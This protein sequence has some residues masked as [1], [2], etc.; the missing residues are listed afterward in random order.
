MNVN[1]GESRMEVPGWGGARTGMQGACFKVWTSTPA[2]LFHH[3]VGPMNVS[4]AKDRS[5]QTIDQLISLAYGGVGLRLCTAHVS[6]MTVLE[7]ACVQLMMFHVEARGQFLVF[8]CEV[9]YSSCWGC[10]AA[11]Y[12]SSCY[13]NSLTFFCFFYIPS[14]TC[15]TSSTYTYDILQCLVLA[16]VLSGIHT[17]SGDIIAPWTL[18][19]IPHST[20]I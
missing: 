11:V 19:L 6:G 15:F 3:L 16:P 2:P 14:A 8:L 20:S 9:G 13:G 5:W 12:T 4:C 17:L 10:S 18:A 1:V 7:C